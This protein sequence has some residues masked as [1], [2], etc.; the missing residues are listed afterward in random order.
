LRGFNR[1]NQPE[2]IGDRVAHAKPIHEL[3]REPPVPR[4]EG[5]NWGALKDVS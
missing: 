1:V 5:L 2:A 4:R 3:A